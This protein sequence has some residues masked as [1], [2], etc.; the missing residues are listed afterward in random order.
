MT[1]RITDRFHATD[2]NGGE[3]T[4]IEYSDVIDVHAVNRPVAQV[5]GV[6][7]YRLEDGTPIQRIDADT[8]MNLSRE[9][10]PL[11]HRAK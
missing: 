2:S 5:S 8:F 3:Y 11:I 6:V 9:D 7:H 4:V 10:L 1:E